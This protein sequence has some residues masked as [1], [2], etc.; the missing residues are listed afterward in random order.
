MLLLESLSST[1]HIWLVDQ[2]LL[3]TFSILQYIS[4]LFNS[5]FL[6]PIIIIFYSGG[7]DAEYA[8]E[9]YLHWQE[10]V[11]KCFS[12]TEALH[13]RNLAEF[14]DTCRISFCHDLKAVTESRLYDTI[15]KMK[16]CSENEADNF[17][18]FFNK[19]IQHCTC[20]SMRDLMMGTFR[21]IKRRV[22]SRTF[23]TPTVQHLTLSWPESW[24]MDKMRYPME[25]VELRVL[26]PM[27]ILGK[28]VS[29]LLRGLMRVVE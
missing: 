16:S 22:Q 21:S 23:I 20:E 14:V 27:I 5:Y 24:G 7:N 18:E 8:R 3:L 11:Y 25:E 10:H 13:C 9:Q 19:T 28:I 26:D 4:H 1:R 6:F 2:T 29:G 12:N 15:R 17:I